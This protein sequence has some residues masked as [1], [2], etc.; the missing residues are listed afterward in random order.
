MDGENSSEEEISVTRSE[1][2]EIIDRRVEQKLK[3]KEEKE[4]V[5][6]QNQELTRRKFLKMA[7]LGAGALGLSSATSALSFSPLGS[8]GGASKQKLSEVLSEG[9]DVNNQDI[10]D[11]GTTIWD[12]NN[13]EIP[14]ASV[15]EANLDADTLDG[16]HATDIGISNSEIQKQIIAHNWVIN[17]G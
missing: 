8:G 15:D 7:G 5:K 14:A 16:Q 17:N 2:E 10:V 11:N 3:Q 1:L 4:T 12:S 9:N 13:N 6:N